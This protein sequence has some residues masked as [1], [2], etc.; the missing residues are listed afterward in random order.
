LQPRAN[1]A[2]PRFPRLPVVGRRAHLDE[3]VRLQRAID[4]RDDLGGEALVADD[5]DRG[6]LV[7]FGAQLASLLRGEGIHRRQYKQKVFRRRLHS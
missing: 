1:L 7:R 2:H 5:H 6:Q 3:L 4:F